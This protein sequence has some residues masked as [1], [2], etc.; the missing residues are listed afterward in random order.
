M[1][2]EYEQVGSEP[3]YEY[4]E[5][6]EEQEIVGYDPVYDWVDYGPYIGEWS[7]DISTAHNYKIEYNK[8]YSDLIEIQL[9]NLDIWIMKYDVNYLMVDSGET[10]PGFADYIF[11]RDSEKDGRFASLESISSQYDPSEN[12]SDIT[13][14]S[15]NSY[16]KIKTQIETRTQTNTNQ[17][18]NSSAENLQSKRYVLEGNPE[19]KEKTNKQAK[20]GDW[21]Y[22]NFCTIYLDAGLARNNISDVES[23]LFEI[24]ENNESTVDMVDLTKYLLYCALDTDYGVKMFNFTISNFSNGYNSFG[25]NTTDLALYLR[26]FSHSGEA[27]QSEDGKYYIM[28]GDGKGWP[29]IGNADLQWKSHHDRF[30]V[31]GKV[32]K[33]GEEEEVSSIEE[34]VNGF[35][36]RGIDAEYTDAEIA[37]MQIYID[38]SIVDQVGSVVQSVYYNSVINIVSESD[39]KLSKQQIYAL[40]AIIYNGG[41]G[42]FLRE[43]NGYTFN[44]V[45]EAGIAQGYSANSWEHNRF[46]WDN[47]WAYVGGGARGHIPARD[48]QFETYVKGVYNFSLSEAGTVFSRNKYIYYTREQL[49][50][51]NENLMS[52]GQTVDFTK[53][54]DRNISNLSNE[55]EIFTMEIAVGVYDT[56]YAYTD[57]TQ[58]PWIKVDGYFE[59]SDGGTATVFNQTYT[60][61]WGSSGSKD[62]LEKHPSVPKENVGR[63]M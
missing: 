13:W 55:I 41:Q 30:N 42:F 58:D 1:T 59:L 26:Q 14:I 19:V 15:L 9:T 29:T 3:I 25:N 44:S 12:W 7:H 34:Y 35:L 2:S 60:S 57:L 40:T 21:D 8:T 52:A 28:Y 31:V 22:P 39:I 47:W 49:E 53:T 36:T 24:L 38:K 17:Y 20:P 4:N 61:Y 33:D 5:E 32:L 46:I 18:F 50:Y 27:P 54:I 10:N 48:A 43:R 62:Y 16:T 37:D 63:K 45:Y 11:E 56:N 51:V 23:W 6:T